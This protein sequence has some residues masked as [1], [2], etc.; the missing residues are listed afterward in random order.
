MTRSQA[1]VLS[2]L[3]TFA[4][5]PR[6]TTLGQVP[7][8][9]TGGGSTALGGGSQTG[10]GSGGGGTVATGGGGSDCPAWC[11]KAVDNLSGL[12]LQSLIPG[13]ACGR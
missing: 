7:D 10:G 2:V 11:R 8:G 9:G 4:C 5:G 3:F 13:C 12:G 1:A 6:T